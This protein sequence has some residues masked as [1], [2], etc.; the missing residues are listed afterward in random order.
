MMGDQSF[1]RK[2]HT[3]YEAQ[4]ACTATMIIRW[5]ESQGMKA[6][7]GRSGYLIFGGLADILPTFL[8]TSVEG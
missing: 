6:S 2:I 1:R 3:P 8:D 5:P 7:R 4:A